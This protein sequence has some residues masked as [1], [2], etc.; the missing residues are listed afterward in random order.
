MN[1]REVLQRTGLLP[2]RSFGQN[3]LDAPSI[4]EA[5]ARACVPDAEIGRHPVVEWGAG[6][7]SLTESLLPRAAHLIAIERDRDLVPVLREL[8]PEAVAACR[9]TVVEGD[10][11]T[12]PLPEERFILAGNLPYQLTG[13]LLR[14]ATEHRGRIVRAVFMVQLEVADRLCATPMHEAYGA[15]SVFAQAA[16]VVTRVRK[17]PPGA[18]IPPPRV[19][20]A[21]VALEGRA[22]A[23]EETD[24]FRSVVSSAFRARRKTLR[25]AWAG[26]GDAHVLERMAEAA[27]TTLTARGETLS[28]DRFAAAAR[29]LEA[30]RARS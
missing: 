23:I 22:D 20:S 11:Q 28:P 14:R 10:A 1:I 3:F 4:S 29:A 13:Q 27:A 7:G 19:H 21:V 6:L 12:V 17:V 30:G 9:L 16:F 15:L 8:F 5:I 2:K 18:F 26:L 25:N 24:A